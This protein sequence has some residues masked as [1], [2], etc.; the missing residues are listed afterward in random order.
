[1]VA[2]WRRL[3]LRIWGRQPSR[4]LQFLFDAKEGLRLNPIPTAGGE[5]S[6]TP[7]PAEEASD[8]SVRGVAW[9][10]G[11]NRFVFLGPRADADFLRNLAEWARGHVREAPA[12]AALMDAGAAVV[13]DDAAA[14]AGVP[15]EE[16]VRAPALWD[17]LLPANAATVA[18]LLEPLWPG[19]RLWAWIDATARGA[20]V[21]V[22]V[23]A[24][25]DDPDHHRMDALIDALVGMDDPGWSG[26]GRLLED[27][28]IQLVGRGL[29]YQHLH[30]VACWV[31]Q[32]VGEHP[33][34]ARLRDL[35]LACLDVNGAVASI[36][37]DP[38]LWTEV[39]RVVAPGTLAGSAS[40]LM[41][42]ET[43]SAL[44]G[45]LSPLGVDEPC[46]LLFADAE[47]YRAAA[48]RLAARFP[49]SF[50]RAHVLSVERLPGG[51]LAVACLDDDS[52]GFAEALRAFADL[53]GADF[54]VFSAL[55]T[56]V[57]STL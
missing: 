38:T 51:E 36:E 26:T 32:T 8:A 10:D 55:S 53:R 56:A 21:P 54:P 19:A 2:D 22:L 35:Q 6:P 23:H 37:E 12:L 1:M 17:E 44:L 31:A 46:F 52:A 5:A 48:D 9:V 30:V 11:G 16:V 42:L 47:S 15:V 20:D 41:K 50:E 57:I 40:E 43:G 13:S 33:G 25:A 4:P 49:D 39:P 27:G 24:L 7:L 29:T 45:W 14:T 3:S 34:L 18:E 28:R